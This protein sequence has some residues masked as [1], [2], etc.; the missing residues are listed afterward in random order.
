MWLLLLRNNFFFFFKGTSCTLI[1]LIHMRRTPVYL[2]YFSAYSGTC[3]SNLV[4]ALVNVSKGAFL[5]KVIV[6][7][8]SLP[9]PS[10]ALKVCMCA[11]YQRGGITSQAVYRTTPWQAA[12]FAMTF[13]NS[14]LA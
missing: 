7:A 10:V 3:P 4:A 8:T 13:R 1:L 11:Y 5:Y 6:S 14:A 2:F 9:S 12:S